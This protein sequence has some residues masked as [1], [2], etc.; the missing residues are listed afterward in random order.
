MTASSI[1]GGLLDTSLAVSVLIVLVLAI[2]RQTARAFGPEAAYLLW[3]AP[4]G[5]LFLPELA[6]LPAPEVEPLPFDALPV[7]T[8][9]VPPASIG[10]AGFHF[11][12][13][14][15][16]ALIVWAA[17]ACVFVVWQLVAQVNFI[18]RVEAC[19][20]PAPSALLAEA[21]VIAEKRGV[22]RAFGVRIMRDQSGPLVA[23]LFRPVIVLPRSFA[24]EYTP[25][26]RQ[27]TLAHEFAHI[28]RG[29]LIVAL[30]AIIFRALQWPNPLAHVAYK[31]FRTDQEAACDAAVLAAH[32][33]FPDAPHAYAAA[34]VKAA[35]GR[36][37][38]PACS[39]SI[40]HHLKE[41]LMLM[42][43]SRVRPVAGRIV[44]A[45]LIAV[46][47]AASASYGYAADK[48]SDKTDDKTAEK[49][50]KVKRVVLIGG[51]DVKVG[52][53][54]KVIVTTDD[55]G[56]M[57]LDL[58]TLL[59]DKDQHWI[60]SGVDEGAEKRI[61]KIVGAD[62]DHNALYVGDCAADGDSPAPAVLTFRDEKK[63]G[64]EHS[65]SYSIICV[66]GDETA[67]PAKTAEALRKAIDKMEADAKK[68]AERRARMIAGLREQLKKLEAQAKAD[69][70]KK[71]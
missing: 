67:D 63:E 31:P 39:L 55:D 10:P 6:I 62:G 45:A 37:A 4:L 61:V 44:A 23:G 38:A 11:T 65:V 3:L 66:S 24:R 46:G 64:D 20:D 47:L 54:R 29:D 33:S 17:G 15:A 52:T 32:K 70:K 43:A 68:D 48:S 50:V 56:K 14:A 12:D 35:R 2:R 28:A 53:K 1:L 30:A 58:E 22:R 8:T 41:R 18:R 59:G 49:T 26:E 21:A 69:K 16:F 9:L 34:I 25:E 36:V 19:S 57:D 71:K 13:F 7:V 27:L 60:V 5:R 42:K 40:A 51:P